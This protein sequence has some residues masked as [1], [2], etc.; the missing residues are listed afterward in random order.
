MNK[1][2]S[3]FLESKNIKFFYFLFSVL[4]LA[5]SFWVGFTQDYPQYIDQWKGV[6]AGFSPYQDANGNFQMFWYGP[7]HNVFAFFYY[8]HPNLP[9]ITF[10]SFW[11]LSSYIIYKEYLKNYRNF[12]YKIGISLLIIT[13]LNPYVFKMFYF[14]GNDILLGG[15]LF[16]AFYYYHKNRFLLAALLFVLSF[17]YKIYPV[18]FFPFLVINTI[19]ITDIKSLNYKKIFNFPFLKWLFIFLIASL[20]LQYVVFG[21]FGLMSYYHVT[22][23]NATSSALF[24]FLTK[25]LELKIPN[26]LSIIVGFLG[27]TVIFFSFVFGKINR[28]SA[29][30]IALLIL[31][32]TSRVFYFSYEISLLLLLPFIKLL[33][34]KKKNTISFKYFYIS[35]IIIA[36]IT[37]ISE[38]LF[39]FKLRNYKGFI[40]LIPNLI[41]ISI[42]LKNP[43]FTKKIV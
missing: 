23:R 18:I 41:L 39:H 30:I 13:L 25:V 7:L 31:F 2:K 24:Y 33:F 11:L 32:I 6:I 9:R 1:L 36:L 10:M 37:F 35:L 5:G 29:M 20:C 22:D 12:N 43:F 26:I 4:I 38:H 16:F 28:Y 17:T 3:F 40:Y 42:L 27:L 14:G 21:K 15:F 34:H 19:R 8:V